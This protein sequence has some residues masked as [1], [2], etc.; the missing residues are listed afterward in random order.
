MN[1]DGYHGSYIGVGCAIPGV[2][3]EGRDVC[4]DGDGT[5]NHVRYNNL[6]N[7]NP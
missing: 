3:P 7:V 4:T 2:P 1:V 6:L 5:P